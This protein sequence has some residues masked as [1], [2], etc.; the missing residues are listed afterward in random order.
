MKAPADVYNTEFLPASL[1]DVICIS[2]ANCCRSL[3]G[4]EV[5]GRCPDVDVRGARGGGGIFDLY[6]PETV[7]IGTEILKYFRSKTKERRN[8]QQQL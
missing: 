8:Q 3:I 1:A 6:I 7:E 5:L 4:V 2:N